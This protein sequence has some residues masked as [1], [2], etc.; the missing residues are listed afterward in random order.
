MI[1]V[2]GIT[3]EFNSDITL[4]ELLVR[5]EL[6]D[7]LCAV[8]VNNTLIPHKQRDEYKLQE[9]DTVEIVSLVGGA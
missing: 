9:G 6:S 1:T 4:Q 3:H 5:L 2:N 8:E 7:S